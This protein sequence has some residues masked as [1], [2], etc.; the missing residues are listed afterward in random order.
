MGG[1]PDP[2][3]QP[4]PNFVWGEQ[5]SNPPLPDWSRMNGLDETTAY[6]R[7]PMDSISKTIN[8]NDLSRITFI[9]AYNELSP[10][11]DDVAPGF[12]ASWADVAKELVATQGTF[13]KQALS[14]SLN[15]SGA[16]HNAVM[17]NLYWSQ[18][19]PM[20]LYTAAQANGT[21][22][23]TFSKV[24]ATT[25]NNIVGNYPSYQ[26]DV[27][28]AL[29]PSRRDEAKRNYDYFAQGV[30]N[31]YMWE[32]DDIMNNIPDYNFPAKFVPAGHT[33]KGNGA[34][35]GGPAVGQL[36][37]NMKSIGDSG[38]PDTV[39]SD[40]AQQQFTSFITDFKTALTKLGSKVAPLAD[41]RSVGGVP[42]AQQA[43]QILADSV[44]GP[45]QYL[46][47]LNNFYAYLDQL[48]QTV[49]A[50]FIR[51]QA[52]DNSP[53]IGGSPGNTSTAG[54]SGRPHGR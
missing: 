30:M 29:W 43:K 9:E 11:D 36:T 28:D 50:A 13:Y 24:I 32:I 22:A 38:P 53:L 35:S 48:G 21:I 2:G 42:S 41:Y 18:E 15:W 23:D 19:I 54:T 6:Q 12:P 25:K 4:P 1:T 16:T 45:G 33:P 26:S 31:D 34:P 40:S 39:F 52:E 3:P 49:D 5:V 44:T 27:T 10:A 8:F 47:T 7:F 51:V 46:D 17:N 37:G 20:Y 14:N